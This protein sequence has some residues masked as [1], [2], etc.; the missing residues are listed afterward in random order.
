MSYLLSGLFGIAHEP[1]PCT[2]LSSADG[3]QTL[4]HASFMYSISLQLC[5]NVKTEKLERE[6]L[7]QLVQRLLR[8]F[9]LL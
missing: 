5:N 1:T 7:R 6:V 2:Q 4:S 9:A 8:D 3:I